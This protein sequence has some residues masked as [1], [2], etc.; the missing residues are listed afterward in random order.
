MNY[1]RDEF[2][3]ST[4]KEII[5]LIEEL[6]SAYSLDE[7]NENTP[8]INEQPVFIDQLDWM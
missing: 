8:E 7:N 4:F 6:N 3:D 5:D 1:S 2:F